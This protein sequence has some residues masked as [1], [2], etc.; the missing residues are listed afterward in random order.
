MTSWFDA[1]VNLWNGVSGYKDDYYVWCKSTHTAPIKIRK[2]GEIM[3]AGQPKKF[4]NGKQL[5][6]LFRT[7]CDE[8]T[9]N[10]FNRVPNQT[11]F[12]KWLETHYNSVDRKTIYTSLNKYFPTIKKDFEQIQSDVIAEGGML[13]HYQPAMSIFALKN[14]CKWSDNHDIKMESKSDGKLADLIEGLKENDLHKKTIA[15]DA[16]VAE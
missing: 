1:D 11:N 14:W 4:R 12:C 16:D 2:G 15:I 13:G 10:E 5:I 8:I 6:E 7:F 3:P 9:A